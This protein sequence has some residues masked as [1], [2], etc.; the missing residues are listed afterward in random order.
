MKMRTP[1]PCSASQQLD[2]V[3]LGFQVVEEQANALQIL[4]RLDVPDEV[5]HAAHDQCATVLGASRPCRHSGG[6]DAL[7]QLVDL[8]AALLALLLQVDARFGQ[9][10]AAEMRVQVV[11]ASTS[12]DVGSPRAISMMRFLHPA[13]LRRPERPAH[14]SARCGR[15]PHV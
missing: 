14:G 15:T 2:D 13:V 10:A 5:G 8:S 3:L 4:Q 9:G 12:A 7:R 11:G 1:S 6:D